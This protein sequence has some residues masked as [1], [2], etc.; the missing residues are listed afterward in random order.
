VQAFGAWR[1]AFDGANPIA[2]DE[3]ESAKATVEAK[4]V[5]CYTVKRMKDPPSLNKRHTNGT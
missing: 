5:L 4:A 3:Q 1:K 2:D